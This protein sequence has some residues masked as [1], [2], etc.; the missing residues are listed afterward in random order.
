MKKELSLIET[1]QNL[2]DSLDVTVKIDY[3]QVQKVVVEDLIKKYTSCVERK[4][5]KQESF[6]IVLLCYLTQEELDFYL[7]CDKYSGEL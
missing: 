4:S 2:I 5:D 3:R 7:L 1:H 6:K